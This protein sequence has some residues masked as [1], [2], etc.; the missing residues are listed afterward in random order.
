MAIPATW[1][2]LQAIER[3]VN[4]SKKFKKE[5]DIRFGT[6]LYQQLYASGFR[7]AKS[8]VAEIRERMSNPNRRGSK[9]TKK[10]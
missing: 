3:L 6:D 10:C 2:D 5:F 1:D 4:D 9:K 7:T 8:M